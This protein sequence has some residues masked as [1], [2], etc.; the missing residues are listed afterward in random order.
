MTPLPALS[1][2]FM[3]CLSA[4]LVYYFCVDVIDGSPLFISPRHG[5]VKRNSRIHACC[6]RWLRLVDCDLD[7]WRRSF[8]NFLSWPPVKPCPLLCILSWDLLPGY[9]QVHMQLKS[10]ISSSTF[11]HRW[12]LL[13]MALK[14]TGKTVRNIKCHDIGCTEDK[15]TNMVYYGGL[16]WLSEILWLPGHEVI[17][18]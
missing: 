3:Y 18:Q 14:V 4:N 7:I 17:R 10:W 1:A 2:K 8:L 5:L 15:Q 6:L 13:S 16:H 12:E 9:I 11:S